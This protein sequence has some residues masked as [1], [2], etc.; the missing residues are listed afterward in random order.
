MDL[1]EAKEFIK[2]SWLFNTANE[3]IRLKEAIATI[4]QEL[5]RLQ[6]RSTVATIEEFKKLYISKDKIKELILNKKQ[7]IQDNNNEI[8]ECRK[9]IMEDQE[10]KKLGL[11]TLHKNNALLELE[12]ADLLDL[13][14]EEKSDSTYEK[15]EERDENRDYEEFWKSIVENEDGTINKE[16]LKKE[17]SDYLMIMD[18]CTR[19]YMLCSGGNISYPNTRFYEVESIFYDKFMVKEYAAEDLLECINEDMTFEEIVTEIKKY[20][21]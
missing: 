1:K 5:E 14:K 8:E 4:L 7:K 17:L 21:E 6:E 19:A 18:N 10:L 3:N 16:Q 13:L 12:I 9:T 20:F 2:N 11:Y 15:E